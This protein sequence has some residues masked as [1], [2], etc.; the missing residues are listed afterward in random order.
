MR[1]ANRMLQVHGGY[2][3]MKEYAIERIYRDLR[4]MEIVGGTSHMQRLAM[5]KMRFAAH[6]VKIG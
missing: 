2:G 1:V 3:Y 4:A 6:K 5:A